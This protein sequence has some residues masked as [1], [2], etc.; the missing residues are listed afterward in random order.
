MRAEP[1]TY[2]HLGRSRFLQEDQKDKRRERRGRAAAGGLVRCRAP[3]GTASHQ[4]F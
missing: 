4:T 1:P 2:G 3:K